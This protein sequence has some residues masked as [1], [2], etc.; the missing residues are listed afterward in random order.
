MHLSVCAAKLS[1]FGLNRSGKLTCQ[2]FLHTHCRVLRLLKA[3]SHTRPEVITF[4]AGAHDRILRHLKPAH[5]KLETV[6]D[7]KLCKRWRG[8]GDGLS[9]RLHD[10]AEQLFAL[11]GSTSQLHVTVDEE[12]LSLEAAEPA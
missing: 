10:A 5:A 3:R 6:C 11:A 8:A 2:H 4:L 12:A 7:E 9:E 1:D